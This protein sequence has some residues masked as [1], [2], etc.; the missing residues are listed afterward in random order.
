MFIWFYRLIFLPAFLI[1]MPYYALRMIR[2]GGYAK[3]FKHRLGLHKILPKPKKPRIWIQA[4][5]VGETE[6]IGTLVKLLSESGKVE[7][8]ITTTTST[9]YK[10]LKDKYDSLCV[11]T[12]IFPWDFAPFSSMAW[13]AIKPDLCVLMESEIWP[14]HLHQAKKRG[15]KTLLVNARMSDKSFGRY[16]KVGKIARA[17]FAPISK[18]LTASAAEAERF[19]KLGIAE[20]KISVMGNLKFD[21]V[22]S[23]YLEPSE[24]AE[25]KK[26]MGFGENALVMMGASTWP[27]EEEV[28]LQTL[29]KIRNSNIACNL[30]IIPRHEERRN[31]IENVLKKTPYKY[32]FR[33]A[34]KVADFPCD[35]YVAD[36]TGEMRILSQVADFA[37]IGKSLPPNN[38]GQTPIDCAALSIAMT[39]GP[40]M[41]NFKAAC[42]GLKDANA[43]LPAK[44]ANEVVDNLLE[45]AKDE[46]LRLKIGKTAKDWHTSNIGAS[47]RCFNAILETLNLQ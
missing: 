22:P 9:G 43:A 27:T 15:V 24:K 45:F 26:Q 30:L 23:K 40:N 20:S 38:G 29:A 31:D 47:K 1:A 17:M 12:G 33:K 18:I 7:L 3:D 44:D 28:L 19:K 6:A 8:V 2:R 25:L 5:S 41:T 42:K 10:I 35:I 21:T 13:N 37:F 46:S 32:N 34:N 39:Y 4:V 14:E 16:S 36:T 11:Y